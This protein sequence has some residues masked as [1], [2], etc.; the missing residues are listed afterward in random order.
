M[1]RKW[2]A[3]HNRESGNARES[4][5]VIAMATNRRELAAQV[6]NAELFAAIAATVTLLSG[7]LYTTAHTWRLVA[8]TTRR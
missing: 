6:P 7:S 2:L 4:G 1:S 5:N 3:Y 8:R